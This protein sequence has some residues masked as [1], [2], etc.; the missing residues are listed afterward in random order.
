MRQNN[1]DA[2][3]V[4]HFLELSCK[5]DEYHPPTQSQRLRSTLYRLWKRSGS[6]ASFED[7]YADRMDRIISRFQ[8]LLD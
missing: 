6:Q 5:H 2:L 8:Q 3:T 7:W 1:P 4:G